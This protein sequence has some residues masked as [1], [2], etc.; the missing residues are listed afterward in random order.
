VCVCVR[1]CYCRWRHHGGEDAPIYFAVRSF[2]ALHLSSDTLLLCYTSLLSHQSLL[3]IP[4]PDCF[5]PFASPTHPQ[6]MR[7]CWVAD[8]AIGGPSKHPP[9]THGLKLKLGRRYSINI[10]DSFV[11]FKSATFSPSVDKKHLGLGA[12]NSCPPPTRG[13]AVRSPL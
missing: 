12:S 4:S 1:A 9:H 13:S 11:V 10:T 8:P 2:S 7:H 6:S 5:S 3:H